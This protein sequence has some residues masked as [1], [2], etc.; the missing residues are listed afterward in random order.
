[1]FL[2]KLAFAIGKIFH[3]FLS[4]GFG[5]NCLNLTRFSKLGETKIVMYDLI[6]G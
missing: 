6:G 2:E 4:F 3:Q 1:M 5:Q